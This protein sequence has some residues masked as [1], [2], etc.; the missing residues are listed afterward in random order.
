MPNVDFNGVWRSEIASSINLRVEAD[1]T[2]RGT[3]KRAIGTGS[4]QEEFP[5][6]GFAAGAL[7]CLS[8]NLGKYG[9]VISWVGQVAEAYHR[10]VIKTMWMLERYVPDPEDPANLEGA[11]VTGYNHFVR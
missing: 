10:P 9:S 8:A 4:A 7:L 1:G 11:T 3:Y 2:V 5:L 6:T